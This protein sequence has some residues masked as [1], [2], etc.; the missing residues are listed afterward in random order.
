MLVSKHPVDGMSRR[1]FMAKLAAAS[2]AGAMMSLAGPVIEKAYGA[3]PC[4]GHL[5]DIEHFVFMLQENRSFDHYF[6]SLSG[7]NGFDTPSSAF[8]QKGW[9]PQTQSIDPAGVTIPYRFDTTRGPLLNGACV[10]D[11]GHQWIDM[12]RAFNNGANDNW[13]GAQAQAQTLQGNVPVTMGYY[14]RQDQPIHYLLADTFTI[15]DG[16]HCSLIGGTSPN[17]LYWMSAWIDPNGEQGGPLLVDPNIQPQ[18]RFSWRTMPDNLSDAGISWKVYQNKLLG[19]LNNTVIG[20]DGMLNDFV[21]A[22]DP[23]SNMARYGIAPTYP[24]D[25]VADVASNRLPQVS[26]VLPG[27]QVSEHPGVP[28]APAVGGTAIVNILRILLSN[29]AVWEK[30]ALIVSFDENGGFFDH[31]T[32]TTAPEGTPGEWITVPDINAVTGSGGIRGPIGLGYR[33]PCFVISPYSRGPL[34]VHDIFDHTSQLRLLEQRFG[35][36]VPNLT[37]WRRGVT[38]DMTSTFNFAVPPNA[39]PP[40]LDHPALKAV[41][42]Q[43]QCVPDTVTVFTKTVPPYRVPFP[44]VMPSQETSPTRGIP[45]GPC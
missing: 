28:V 39:S 13:L 20:Y 34:M 38:G 37:T 42:Q 21:Q 5:T 33:V 44:Q 45:S 10:N 22:R 3:G 23:R 25:F 31:V 6:G 2:S 27:F 16:Y 40:N 17:R 32:P 41:P 24:L 26:W 12:H 15:C 43:V 4:S 35:V 11:P 8:Q 9:N 29:P 19:A 18:G 7:I 36:P 1:E 30:T 14:T